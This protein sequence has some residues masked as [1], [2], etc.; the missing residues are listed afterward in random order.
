LNQR[1]LA[2]RRKALE[3]LKDGATKIPRVCEAETAF[4]IHL[5]L[6]KKKSVIVWKL[7]EA[8]CSD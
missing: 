7:E 4:T 5:Q 8:R 6:R 2:F 1:K 3:Y